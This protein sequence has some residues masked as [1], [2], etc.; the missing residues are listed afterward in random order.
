MGVKWPSSPTSGASGVKLCC[1]GRREVFLP[2]VNGRRRGGPCERIVVAMSAS[3]DY[4][5]A[6]KVEHEWHESLPGR[7]PD[8]TVVDFMGVIEGL[9]DELSQR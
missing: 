6:S 2:Y 1:E 8:A 9:A 4:R 7:R 3:K 5:T